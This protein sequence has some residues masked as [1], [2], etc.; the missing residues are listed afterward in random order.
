MEKPFTT[1]TVREFVALLEKANTSE[2]LIPLDAAATARALEYLRAPKE[3]PFRGPENFL[4]RKNAIVVLYGDDEDSLGFALAWLALC[5]L[6][7]EK[8]AE[9]RFVS[10]MHWDELL[11]YTKQ[12]Q[13]EVLE[14]NKRLVLVVEESYSRN[15]DIP[16]ILMH[17][18]DVVLKARKVGEITQVVDV[19]K[20]RWE[21]E[22]LP[23]VITT[24]VEEHKPRI[25]RGEFQF[26]R[27]LEFNYEVYGARN[28]ARKWKHHP[29]TRRQVMRLANIL[30]PLE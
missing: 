30:D 22:N 5:K 19:V 14:G 28:L 6:G 12:V 27:V 29:K 4:D 17:M 24:F 11:T 15:K 25:L 8:D 21:I 2:M 23:E 20:C 18:A 10:R 26:P 1:Q 16:K 3:L 13:M 7:P 9:F